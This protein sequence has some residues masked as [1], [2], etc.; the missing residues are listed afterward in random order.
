MRAFLNIHVLIG[1]ILIIAVTPCFSEEV[2]SI[3]EAIKLGDPNLV[4]AFLEQGMDIN[5]SDEYGLT[6]LHYAVLRQNKVIIRLLLEK[7][8]IAVD[9][10]DFLGRTALHYA[11]GADF[12]TA[13]RY[14]A[15]PVEIVQL[16]L[17]SGA[18][19]NAKDTT[20]RT[21][22]FYAVCEPDNSAIKFLVDRGA[23]LHCV[24][25]RGYTVLSYVNCQIIYSGLL[26][27]SEDKEWHSAMK[28]SATILRGLMKDRYCVYVACDGNDANP[29]TLSS[30]FKTITAALNVVGPDDRIVVRGGTYH[31]SIPIHL[32]KSGEL[33]RPIRIIAYPGEIPILD[34]SQTKGV[35]ILVT[36]AYLHFKNLSITGVEFGMMLHGEECHHNVLEQ[37]A[38]YKNNSFETISMREKSACNI[39]VNCDAYD[40]FDLDFHGGSSDGFKVMYGVGQGNTLIG[41]RSWHNSD[42]GFDLFFSDNSVRL[43]QCYAWRNG[44][45]IWNS[46]FFRGDG[47]GFKLGGGEGRHTLI[48]CVACSNNHSGFGLNGN[49]SGVILRNCTAWNNETNYSFSWRGW[50]EEGRKNSV[51]IN[52][53]SCKGKRRDGIHREAQNQNNSWN[54]DLK[55]ALTDDDFISLDGSKMTTPRNRDGSIPYNNFLRLAPG[56]AAID[57]GVD[58]NM[59]YVGKAPDLGA[60][61]YDPNENAEN[62]V[63]M[64]HQY[65]RDHNIEKINEFMDAGTDINEKDWLGYAP[66]HWACYFGYT[67]LVELLISKGADANLISD[68][69]RTPSEIAASMGYENIVDLLCKDANCHKL[70]IMMNDK[71]NSKIISFRN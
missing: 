59:P 19:I 7:K 54:S 27:S 14:D 30:P 64:L 9:S 36:G 6:A 45:N 15:W 2:V 60:F 42:D 17:D 52:N 12:G 1:F 48:N 44:H 37:L 71:T 28:E 16:L 68:T 51:F 56:S 10:Q 55:I 31:C 39:I 63:K 3:H 65:I 50:P 57:A 25:N 35:A 58:V 13:Y 11:A 8:E 18:D 21:P 43:E 32:N 26:S 62:Y 4:V 29:G 22:L 20:G 34:F 47:I 66:L 53:I 5:A 70:K 40:N 24:D 69:G 67:D 33:G 61:E 41:N 46:A 49:S 23:D 38:F